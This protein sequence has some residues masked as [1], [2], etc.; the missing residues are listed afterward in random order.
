[1]EKSTSNKRPFGVTVIIILLLISLGSLIGDL[2]GVPI[3]QLPNFLPAGLYDNVNYAIILGVGM[4]VFQ[5]VIIIGLWRLQRLAWFLLMIQLG[6]SMG[7]GLGAYFNGHKLYSYM[8]LNVI[9]VFYL[10]QRDVQHAFGY[11]AK[12]QEAG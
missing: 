8:L 10:N 5:L 4:I 1:M 7:I 6:V 12:G 9:M 2:T 11:Q 3:S